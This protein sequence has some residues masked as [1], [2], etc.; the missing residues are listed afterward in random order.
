MNVALVMAAITLSG[1]AFM[2]WFLIALLRESEPTICYW[3]VPIRKQRGP[4]ILDVGSGTYGVEAS[5]FTRYSGS[6]Y[7]RA[8]LENQ[9]HAREECGSDL[10]FIDGPLLSKRLS[11]STN[12]QQGEYDF[13]ERRIQYRE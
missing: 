9:N 10:F 5:L 6:N 13:R 7:R 11:W 3:V 8:G 1:A 12:Q 4:E 2:L